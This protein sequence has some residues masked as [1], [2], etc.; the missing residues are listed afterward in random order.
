MPRPLITFAVIAFNQE[1]FV[2]EAVDGAFAQSYEP[3]EILLSDDGSSDG[4]FELM[5]AAAG[6]YGGP[7]EV[8]LNRNDRNLGLAGHVNRVME[9]SRGELVTIAAGDDVSLPERVARSYGI[10]EASQG[11]VLSIH[12]AVIAIDE[13][14]RE[15]DVWQN[16]F[17]DRLN[18]LEFWAEHF[19]GVTGSS[20]TWHRR[21]FEHFGPLRDD[22]VLEDHT[23]AF[24]SALLGTIAYSANPLVRRRRHGASLMSLDD[25]R[26][27]VD[28]MRRRHRTTYSRFAAAARQQLADYAMV[29]SRS[30]FVERGLRR[31]AAEARFRE[32]VVDHP[33]TRGLGE[34][35]AA[36]RAGVPLLAV[37]RR[38]LQFS[39]PRCY[40][41]AIRVLRGASD[42]PA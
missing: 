31:K 1:R 34:G 29:A 9:L 8:R 16:S 26:A 17:Q 35:W 41:L 32:A 15:F 19:C 27:S 6:R 14:G 24:R 11:R 2:R 40:W 38:V 20:H 7:H 13:E 33:W 12:S 3:L 10:W 21:V 36:F 39:F 42:K 18:D 5:S 37:L 25:A 28:A 22:V 30:P 23:I 4:T